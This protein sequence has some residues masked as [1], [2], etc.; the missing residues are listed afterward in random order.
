MKIV[1]GSDVKG[2]NQK[3]QI[4]MHL[5]YLGY[6]VEDL[7]PKK[8]NDYYDATLAVVAYIQANKEDKGIVIDEYGVG[9][10]IIANK[11]KGIICANLF[12][13]HSAKMT[14]AHNNTN[15]ITIGSGIV[16]DTLAKKI[17]ETFVAANYEGGRHQIRVDMLNKMC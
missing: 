9:P 16:G 11:F 2:F 12:D 3:E 7:T 1:V 14:R 5:T 8:V 6:E 17:V 4:K 10:F 13:E 15:L